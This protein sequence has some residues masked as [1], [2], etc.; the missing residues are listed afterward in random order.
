MKIKNPSEWP[1][2][3]SAPQAV[4]RNPDRSQIVGLLLPSYGVGGLGKKRELSMQ[5][6][7]GLNTRAV[8]NPNNRSFKGTEAVENGEL[9]H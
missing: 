9:V 5:C 2:Q 3:L 8:K 4:T 7:H 6:S 1:H